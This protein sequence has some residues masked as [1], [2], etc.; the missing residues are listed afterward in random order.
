MLFGTFAVHLSRQRLMLRPSVRRVIALLAV[1]GD[2][3][4]V[5]TLLTRLARMVLHAAW[6]RER[7][8]H[9]LPPGSRT[10]RHGNSALPPLVPYIL[11]CALTVQRA[12]PGPPIALQRRIIRYIISVPQVYDDIRC[13]A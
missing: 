6:S 11:L 4:R 8:G 13:H 3:R 10:L 1:H 7:K 2:L 5:K 12:S 9:D